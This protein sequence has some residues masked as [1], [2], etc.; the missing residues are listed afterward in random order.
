[1]EEKLILDIVGD[2]EE[3]TFEQVI[4]LMRASYLKGILKYNVWADSVPNGGEICDNYE[5]ELRQILN[6]EE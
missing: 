6:G 2:T 1:M 5:E 3:F 4:L